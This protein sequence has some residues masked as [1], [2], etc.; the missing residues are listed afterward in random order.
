MSVTRRDSAR[1]SHRVGVCVALVTALVGTALV[2]LV[3][4]GGGAGD[5]GARTASGTDP[6]VRL[7]K[8]RGSVVRAATLPLARAAALGLAADARGGGIQ[9]QP[10]STD[11]YKMVAVTW[12]TGNPEVEVRVRRTRGWS[13]WTH[14]D[15][16]T[17]LPTVGEAESRQ[18]E[19]HGT[20]LLWVGEADGVQVRSTDRTELELVLIDPGELATDDTATPSTTTTTTATR[21][22][23]ARRP[24]SA[25]RPPLYDRGVWK[26]NPDWLNGSPYYTNIIKQVHVHHTASANG[27][28]RADV[29]AIL[30]GM[31]R[32]HT[33]TLGWFDIGYNFLV[34]RFGRS[35][36][37][38][39]GGARKR[40]RGAHTL[41][42][43]HNSVG[44]AVIGNYQSKNP[45]RYAVTA[46]VRLAAW[47]LDLDGQHATGRTWMYSKGSD[48]Y[49]AGRRVALYRIDGHR[50]TNDTACP[51]ARLYRLLPDIRTRAERR[52]RY[53]S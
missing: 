21:T 13:G 20:E 6:D 1:P 16:L 51:G 22:A 30:R 46:I 45:T 23:T 48:K 8:D 4:S 36:I 33:Q 32:Y 15:T 14:L 42:F 18:A 49:P 25:P 53:Y 26:P 40:V 39:S 38:R 19:R 9:T 5:R 11:D 43:N 24:R 10:M 35:W 31:Y 3:W 7:V 17:D 41:G 52:L 37:G 50:D 29:P 47:K 27:Y 34:D 44:I 12:E 2:A 28:S